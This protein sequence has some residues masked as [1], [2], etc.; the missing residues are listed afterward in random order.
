MGAYSFEFG[1]GARRGVHQHHPGLR[2][3]GRVLNVRAFNF[4]LVPHHRDT[5][6]HHALN[7]HHHRRPNGQER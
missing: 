5:S 3:D 4:N 6:V 7:Q 1:G 2:N